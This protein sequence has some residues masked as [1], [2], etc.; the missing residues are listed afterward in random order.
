MFM[1]KNIIKIPKHILAS[2]FGA[3][4]LLTLSA[5]SSEKVATPPGS[6]DDSDNDKAANTAIDNRQ[7]S[8]SE[9]KCSGCGKC[10]RTDP[11]HFAINENRKVEVISNNNLSSSDLAVAISICHERAIQLL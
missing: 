8:I 1:M 5:C 2:I 9:Y 11:E 10:I 4:L 3:T 6:T 7:L